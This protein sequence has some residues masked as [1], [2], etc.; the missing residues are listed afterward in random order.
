MICDF[1]RALGQVLGHQSHIV[2]RLGAKQQSPKELAEALIATSPFAGRTV[3]LAE[4]YEVSPI[5]GRQTDAFRPGSKGCLVEVD[6]HFVM[7]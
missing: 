5:K 3:K 4:D 7:N 1:W 2:I 6:F